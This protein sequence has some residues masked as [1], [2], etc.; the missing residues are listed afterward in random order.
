MHTWLPAL[1]AIGAAMGVAVGTV[2]RHRASAT[3]QTARGLWLLGALAAFG[4]FALQVVALGTGSLLLVQPLIVLSVLFALPFDKWINGQTATRRQWLWGVL[5]A[6][7]VGMFVTFA[8]PEPARMGRRLWVLLL[9]VFL[10]LAI[11]VA[12]VTYAERARS[13]P[14]A[15]LYGTVSGSLFGIAAV[16]V[17][18]VGHDMK[19]PLDPLQHPPLYLFLVVAS[20]AVL[21][22]QRSFAAGK[23]Q[24]SFPA[25]TVAEPIVSV[26]LGLAVVGEKLN[27]HSWSTVVSLVGLAVMVV[28]VLRLSRLTAVKQDQHHP[29]SGTPA[30]GT[31]AP[32]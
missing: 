7:G 5:L 9:V 18:A 23:L 32:N 12:M 27:R 17:N 8:D 25:M 30:A 15:L 4:G 6:L 13:A 3:G 28:G 14:R 1:L 31:H 10:V 2:M 11:L 20:A 21:C 29:V 26:A 22:Q 16:L 24:S 19:H